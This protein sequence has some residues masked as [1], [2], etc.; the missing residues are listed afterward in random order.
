MKHALDTCSIE[1]KRTSTA[2]T[3]QRN[4]NDAAIKN[5]ISIHKP[6]KIRHLRYKNQH[7]CL[8]NDAYGNMMFDL[9]HRHKLAENRNENVTKTNSQ[10]QR[11]CNNAR[12]DACAQILWGKFCVC[13]IVLEQCQKPAHEH[14]CAC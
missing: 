12:V 4:N 5:V 3:Q 13:R 14:A 9:H 7:R 8:N 1:K 2:V 11:K 10:F 6:L